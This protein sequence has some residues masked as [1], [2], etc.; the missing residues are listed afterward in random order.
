MKDGYKGIPI[1]KFIGWKSKMYCVV[2][3]NVEETNKAKGVNVSVEF[4][5]ICFV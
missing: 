1:N 3:E 2:A 5:E 4:K